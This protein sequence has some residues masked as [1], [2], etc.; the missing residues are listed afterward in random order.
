MFLELCTEKP[1]PD[2]GE[3]LLNAV[4]LKWDRT[5]LSDI[6]EYCR[7]TRERCE[8]VRW[9]NGGLHHSKAYQSGIAYKLLSNLRLFDAI[10]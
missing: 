3:S 10:L 7:N 2:S 8:A 6:Q 9:L 4:T 5:D 1:I